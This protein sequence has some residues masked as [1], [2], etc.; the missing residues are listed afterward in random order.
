MYY[1][2]EFNQPTKVEEPFLTYTY[3]YENA[4]EKSNFLSG[5]T[6]G[7]EAIATVLVLGAF[8]GIQNYRL[9]NEN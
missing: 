9:R 3:D 2:I 5:I 6:F 1:L 8:G 7:P 4:E